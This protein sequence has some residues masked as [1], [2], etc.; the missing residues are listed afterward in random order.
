MIIDNQNMEIKVLYP[1]LSRYSWCKKELWHSLNA[2]SVL[3]DV[4]IPSTHSVILRSVLCDV[5]IPSFKI[6]IKN[7][8]PKK[9]RSSRPRKS[10]GSGW[11]WWCQMRSSRGKAPLRMTD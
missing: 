6:F 5:R 1:P 2:R 8:K 9:M 11:R 10:E 3:C 4:R 7:K